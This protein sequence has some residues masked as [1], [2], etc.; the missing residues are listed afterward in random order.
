MG[1]TVDFDQMRLGA[2]KQ[3]GAWIYSYSQLLIRSSGCRGQA[4]ARRWRTIV[5]RPYIIHM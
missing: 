3:I 5:N 1:S 2:Q 4:A